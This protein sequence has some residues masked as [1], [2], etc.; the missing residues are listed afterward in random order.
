MTSVVVLI[1]AVSL[2]LG[3]IVLFST[4]Y[5]RVFFVIGMALVV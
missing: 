5:E 4:D 3:Y 1:S 2:S